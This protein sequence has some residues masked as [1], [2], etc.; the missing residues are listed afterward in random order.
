MRAR[1]PILSETAFKLGST[2]FFLKVAFLN[3]F[4][5]SGF[6][7]SKIVTEAKKTCT[8]SSIANKHKKFT[9][10]TLLSVT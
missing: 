5:T 1:F 8:D 3:V 10:N 9:V 4:T 6:T 2:Y 7:G